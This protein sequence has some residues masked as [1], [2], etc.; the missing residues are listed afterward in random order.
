MNSVNR[1]KWI[2]IGNFECPRNI[3]SPEC[4]YLGE[5]MDNNSIENHPNKMTP[6]KRKINFLI[7]GNTG[8][9]RRKNE[10]K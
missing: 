1:N 4:I 5:M 2:R 9:L 3:M 6:S 7:N 8:T 10:N